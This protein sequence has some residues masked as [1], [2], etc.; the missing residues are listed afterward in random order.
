MAERLAEALDL[1]LTALGERQPEP[2]LPRSGPLELDRERLGGARATLP[3][4]RAS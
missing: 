4:T 1:V 3:S 2:A